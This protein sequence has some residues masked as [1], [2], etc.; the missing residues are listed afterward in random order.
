MRARN[1]SGEYSTESTRHRDDITDGARILPPSAAMA[2][3]PVRMRAHRSTA[4]AVLRVRL[5]GAAARSRLR[6]QLPRI[7]GRACASFRAPLTP[8]HALQTFDYTKASSL[9]WSLAH[10]VG[11]GKAAVGDVRRNA[12]GE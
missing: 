11:G 5:E 7:G 4:R 12:G 3:L 10:T 2:E 6:P 1:P 9:A 8:R